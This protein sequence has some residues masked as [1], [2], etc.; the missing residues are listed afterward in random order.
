MIWC[1]PQKRVIDETGRPKSCS[2]AY[3]P[4]SVLFKP[5]DKVLVTGPSARIS[6][7]LSILRTTTRVSP[8]ARALRRFGPWC[9][10][11]QAGQ[12]ARCRSSCSVRPT[13][14]PLYYSMLRSTSSTTT[15][16]TSL[17]FMR[18]RPDG[19]KPYVQTA[20]TAPTCCT[21]F[22]ETEHAIYICGLKGMRPASTPC[23]RTAFTATASA[24]EL[25]GRIRPWTRAT[26]SRRA[27]SRATAH[28]KR[29]TR[30]DV[31]HRM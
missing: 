21:N 28:L 13:E 25:E 5:G 18:R 6:S 15:S 10:S 17:P 12:E 3:A 4:L 8:P 14:R 22:V 24:P 20:K 7:C 9:R 16:I 1:R 30:K 29:C 26:K 19:T 2:R 31:G 11:A 23:L 27:S